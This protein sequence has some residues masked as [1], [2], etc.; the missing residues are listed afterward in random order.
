[1]LSVMAVSCSV[2]ELIDSPVSADEAVKHETVY[3]ATIDDQP[4]GADTK[5][6]AD[7]QL[8]VLWNAKDHITIFDKS[9]RNDKYCFDGEDGANSGSFTKESQGYGTGWEL[10][11][12]YAVYP[13]QTATSFGDGDVISFTLPSEQTYLENSFGHGANTMAAKTN[14]ASDGLLRFKN[15]GGFLRFS[16]YGAGVYVSSVTLM[17]N[18]GE[19]LAGKCSIAFQDGLPV[20]TMSETGTTGKITL[21]CNKPKELGSSASAPTD[22]WIVVPPTTF[23]KGITFIVETSDGKVFSRS[24]SAEFTLER[25]VVMDVPVMQVN[26]V[27]PPVVEALNTTVL[28]NDVDNNGKINV[29][30]SWP[31]FSSLIYENLGL[32]Y[33]DFLADYTFDGIWGNSCVKDAVPDFTRIDER[34]FD[35][36]PYIVGSLIFTCYPDNNDWG[37][38]VFYSQYGT[39]KYA[40]SWQADPLSIGEDSNSTIYF[41]FSK[42]ASIV[43]FSMTLRVVPPPAF[44]LNK[45]AS[46]WFP[47]VDPGASSTVRVNA[48]VPSASLSTPVTGGDVKVFQAD[49][50]D[51]FV[52]RK[53]LKPASGISPYYTENPVTTSTSFVFTQDQP[54]INGVQLYSNWYDGDAWI[55]YVGEYEGGQLLT[56]EYN[57]ITFPIIMAKNIIA[58]ID[59]GVISFYD[60][61]KSK[62][63][64]NLWS[65]RSTSQASMLYCNVAARSTYGSAY[66]PLPDETFHVRFLR[67]ADVVF[68]TQSTDEP[69]VIDGVRFE[70]SKFITGIKDWNNRD[71]I[72]RDQDRPDIFIPNVVQ[73]VNLYAYYQF[74]SL[75]V[76]LPNAEINGWN[77]DPSEF[78]RLSMAAPGAKLHIGYL[79]QP[80]VYSEPGFSPTT[81]PVDPFVLDITDPDA[82]RGVYFHYRNDGV[83]PDTF[84][85]RVPVRFNYAWGSIDGY[86]L[87]HFEE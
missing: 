87:M 50:F 76:D 59:N 48:A 42:G 67:P 46:K 35:T 78:G 3:R 23:S 13:Y 39:D 70:F 56:D 54:V 20:V 45:F 85:L 57:G 21:K 74:S 37:D 41:R 33:A 72:V 8:R 36:P 19:K 83:Y 30:L 62:E 34:W 24:S 64:L 49:L 63:L 6:Y 75:T 18:N 71:I 28:S 69:T 27:A 12:A 66:T 43:Y 17:G 65:P 29:Y 61:E 9:S 40:L 82:L 4:G 60:T 52:N 15:V 11:C 16:F 1:M 77:T 25:N 31:D 73:G 32:G 53:P 84:D 68:A 86:F 81:E 10:P 55:L 80:S 22:F 58:E 26:A 14:G 47:D 51:F 7:A 44:T 2:D 5:T 79:V 38:G